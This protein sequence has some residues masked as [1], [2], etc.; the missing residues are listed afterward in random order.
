MNQFAKSSAGETRL[1][2]L[3]GVVSPVR[4]LFLCT[5]NS[6]RS[7]MAEGLLR[8]QGKGTVEVMSAGTAP[9][10]IHP[11]TIGAMQEIGVDISSQQSK[12][13]DQFAGERFDYVI[14]LCGDAQETCPAF[15]GAPLRLHWP[16]ADPT[17]QLATAE[18]RLK[19]FRAVRDDLAHR[20]EDLLSEILDGFLHELHRAWLARSA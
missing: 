11:N 16:I 10:P 7:Q 17:A 15:P 19:A 4:V 2:A 18:L 1:P 13:V 8:S 3:P 6:C 5:A 9:K 20:V 12:S 14:T